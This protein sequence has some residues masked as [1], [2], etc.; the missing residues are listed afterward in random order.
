MPFRPYLLRASSSLLLKQAG[1]AARR[2]YATE[3]RF[4][5]NE[6]ARPVVTT[7]I[8]GPKAK[9]AIDDIDSVFDTNNINMVTDFKKSVGN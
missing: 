5:A 4:F 3:A 9:S 2:R 6:P 8:P 1:T 7:S